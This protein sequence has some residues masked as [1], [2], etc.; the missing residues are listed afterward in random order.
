MTQPAKLLPVIFGEIHEGVV[1][2]LLAYFRR[3]YSS[4]PLLFGY[5]ISMF[6]G[7]ELG[8]EGSAKH[9]IMCTFVAK[10]LWFPH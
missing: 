2:L 3:Q 9:N 10:L 1:L 6:G 8:V 4:P 7:I 5:V